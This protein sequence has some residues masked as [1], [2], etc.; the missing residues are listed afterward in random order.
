MRRQ[1][2]LDGRVSRNQ[3][4]ELCRT[5]SVKDHVARRPGRMEATPVSDEAL[6]AQQVALAEYVP[7]SLAAVA[8]LQQVD[9][10]L[11]NQPDHLHFGV[12]VAKDVFFR[13]VELHP[14][15]TG[16]IEQVLF[17]KSIERRETFEKIGHA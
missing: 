11:L 17:R 3:G 12:A 10:S 7:Q 8:L 4:L 1:K 5:D 16:D 6:E 9:A 2:A 15:L 13:L 14:S